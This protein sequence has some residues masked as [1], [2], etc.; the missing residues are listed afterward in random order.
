MMTICF[1]RRRSVLWV[2]TRAR[3]CVCVCAQKAVNRSLKHPQH[4]NPEFSCAAALHAATQG[5]GFD[6]D[7]PL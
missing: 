7:V 5:P 2:H 1:C 4:L 6:A 3:F